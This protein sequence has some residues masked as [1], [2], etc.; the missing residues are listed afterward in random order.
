[1][2]EN[3]QN[4][5]ESKREHPKYLKV[6][7]FRHGSSEY[8]ELNPDVPTSESDLTEEG[9][10]EIALGITAVMQELDKNNDVIV[11]ASSPKVRAIGSMLLAKNILQ[12]NGFTVWESRDDSRLIR[13]KIRSG[14][15]LDSEGSPIEKPH[16]G[17]SAAQRRALQ[18]V[19]ELLNPGS[20]VP[21]TWA[22]NPDKISGFERFDDVGKRANEEVAML[23]K[24][25]R[26]VQSK[27]EKQIVVISFEHGETVDPVIRMLGE[28][29]ISQR[30]G[31]PLKKGEPL[32][33]DISTEDYSMRVS[34]PLRN[35][36][37]EE[38]INFDK[39]TKTF[40][41]HENK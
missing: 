12:E 27:T 14:D 37:A 23:F 2:I 26:L 28:G 20:D 1:M 10:R 41:Y 31:S 34:L 25:A 4:S 7:R 11:L 30:K 39:Q 36:V 6:F 29:G 19:A 3:F 35:D 15:T 32:R 40:T 8:S 33:M 38:V 21:T 5:I 9:N 17:F 16:P 22:N 18:Q 24:V 13:E